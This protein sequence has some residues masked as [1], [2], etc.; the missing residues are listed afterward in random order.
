MVSLYNFCSGLKQCRKTIYC[1]FMFP[2][3]LICSVL[4]YLM[5]PPEVDFTFLC[6]VLLFGLIDKSD[7]F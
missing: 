3:V 7:S 5:A 2:S 6:Y 4:V 1:F